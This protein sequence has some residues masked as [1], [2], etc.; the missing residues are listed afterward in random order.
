MLRNMKWKIV[1]PLYML[2]DASMRDLKLQ[3]CASDAP[4]WCTYGSRG[5]EALESTLENRRSIGDS[6]EVEALESTL[7]NRRSIG[8]SREVEVFVFVAVVLVIL[9]CYRKRKSITLKHV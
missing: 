1:H 2:S 7:E 3:A 6:R 8:D 9:V 5:V 4:T